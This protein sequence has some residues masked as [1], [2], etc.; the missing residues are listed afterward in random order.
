[1]GMMHQEAHTTLQ[2]G[3]ERPLSTISQLNPEDLLKTGA[4]LLHQVQVAEGDQ[5]TAVLRLLQADLLKAG[6][7]LHLQGLLKAE[8]T[9]LHHLVLP[10]QEVLHLR[11]QGHHPDLLL[12]DHPLQDPV[13]E[14]VLLPQD[15]QGVQAG[16]YLNSRELIKL[17]AIF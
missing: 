16:K 9:P 10:A 14:E 15:H 1:M 11:P 13:Q 17:P 8:V 4:I 6:I 5:A 7:I 2:A 3:K 12:P